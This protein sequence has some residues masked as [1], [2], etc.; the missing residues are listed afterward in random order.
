M[1]HNP[2]IPRRL[3]AGCKVNLYLR[4]GGKRP[5]SLHELESIFFPLAYPRDRLLVV[6]G[7]PG[8]GLSVFCSNPDIDPQENIL[9]TAYSLFG[10]Q[11]GFWPDLRVHL[12]KRIPIGAG[13]GGGSSDAARFLLYLNESQNRSRRLPLQK[14]HSLSLRIGA[15][16][17]FFLHNQPALV[18]GAGERVE[19]VA[20]DL[21]PY[22]LLLVCPGCR[23][24]TKA[25]YQ[26]FDDRFPP[27]GSAAA[28]KDLTA[29]ADRFT[30]SFRFGGYC[31]CN[32]FEQVVFPEIPELRSLKETL[33]KTGA[34]AA[35]LSGSGSSLVALFHSQRSLSQA[36][37]WLTDNRISYFI[38]RIG[39]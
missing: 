7:E 2:V 11:A 6:P 17:P 35:V 23:V 12:Q 32:D 15:D 26:L 1:D 5:G 13:L 3:H 16:V 20:I 8:S 33:L 37:S 27:T 14:L 36:S 9:G 18:T 39:V 24:S 22:T 21:S 30:D 34:V 28:Q 38:N 19:P 29:R 4:I 25:A 31:L 10:E